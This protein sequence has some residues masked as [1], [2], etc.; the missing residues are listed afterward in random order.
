[1]ELGL[2]SLVQMGLKID[3]LR[4]VLIALSLLVT[5]LIVLT[6]KQPIK[7]SLL[8][9]II[10]LINLSLI[11]V[12]LIAQG[13][14]FYFIFEASLLP[15]IIIIFGWG[16]QPER[17]SA[18]YALIFYTVT[19]S[20]P[21]LVFLLYLNY[22]AQISIILWPVLRLT[23]SNLL[24]WMR[25]FILIGF[26]VKLP[27]F[28]FHLWLPKAHV[29]APVVGSIILAALLL[30]LGGYGIWRFLALFSLRKIRMIRQRLA[31]IGGALIAILCIQQTDIK[32]LIAYSSVAHIR[33]VIAALLS[34][35]PLGALSALALMVA[36]GVSSSAI[37]AGANFIYEI[38][39]TR[40]LRL[41]S[42]LLN[43]FP[44]LS[45]FWFLACLG[46]MGAPPTI[47]L[48]REIWAIN[49][50]ASL[51]FISWVP[52][53]IL[54][55]FAAAYTLIL[56]S[57]SQ[58]GQSR[59]ALLS[60]SVAPATSILVMSL[61]AVWLV[62]GFMLFIYSN[63]STLK[64]CNF[65]IKRHF[66]YFRSFFVISPYSRFGKSFSL[67][68]WIYPSNPTSGSFLSSFFFNNYFV[69]SIWCRIGFTFSLPALALAIR[70]N[71]FIIFNCA[72]F[73]YLGL[74]YWMIS[75]H[76]WVI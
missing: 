14:S 67:W 7:K 8:I 71:Y 73:A 47:N 38:T 23:P 2:F 30:K 63:F 50:T 49:I 25:G 33:L 3:E 42:G 62:E 40:R 74:N 53:S 41:T 6:S 75:K 31:L 52:I 17:I 37:F 51:S 69:F 26:L 22:L 24:S 64:F 59:Q 13:L 5:L 39:H 76:T 16:Y 36:H 29:E 15:I 10:W 55:F 72:Y 28:A 46:N 4:I 1:M 57:S 60:R 27:I 35:T 21:L 20:F 34:Q 68:M 32:I 11:L 61:H 9:L 19:A 70:K 45:L 43:Y 44:I 58:Q 65:R 66:T 54:S 18:A 48:I 12:F 56:Y